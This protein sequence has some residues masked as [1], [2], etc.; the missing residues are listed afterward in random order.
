MWKLIEL[1][2][3]LKIW[4]QFINQYETFR[5]AEF[6]RKINSLPQ[7]DIVSEI[8]KMIENAKI[9]DEEWDDNISEIVRRAVV[10]TLQELLQKFNPSSTNQTSLR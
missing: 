8:E 9:I 3:A 7:I 1:D 10:L 5:V 4:L 6:T 2:E